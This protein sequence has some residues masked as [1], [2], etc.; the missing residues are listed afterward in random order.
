MLDSIMDKGRSR[1]LSTEE[2]GT[3]F[4]TEASATSEEH[5]KM[6]E[7]RLRELVVDNQIQEIV[8]KVSA[9]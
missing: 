2:G 8:L 4:S 3:E 6:S 5:K 1:R 7:S 9:H